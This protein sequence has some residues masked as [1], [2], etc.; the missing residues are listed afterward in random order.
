MWVSRFIK[1][2]D[3]ELVSKWTTGLDNEHSKAD[4]AFKYTLYF[5]LLRQKIEKFKIDRRQIYNMDEKGFL[6]SVLVKM[7]RIFSRRRYEEGGVRQ[8]LQDGNREWITVIAC[9]CADGTTLSP[10]L[11]YRAIT[12]LIQDSWLQDF[13]NHPCFFA[14]SPTGWTN[15]HLG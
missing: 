10:G 3:L 2:H 9:I 12:G 5:E 1:R 6:I 14:S 13:D 11:I 4:S 7:K 15:D 8:L